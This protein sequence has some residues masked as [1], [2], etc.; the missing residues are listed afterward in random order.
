LMIASTFFIPRSFGGFFKLYR[1]GQRAK[2]LLLLTLFDYFL[3]NY[4]A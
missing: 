4:V 1:R 3:S 2:S